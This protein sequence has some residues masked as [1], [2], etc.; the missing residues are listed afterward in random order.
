MGW[1]KAVR[2]KKRESMGEVNREKGHKNSVRNQ[3]WH[4]TSHCNQHYNQ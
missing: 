2:G 4:N 1:K 3:Q